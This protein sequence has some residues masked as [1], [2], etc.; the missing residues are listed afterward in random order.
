M[1]EWQNRCFR[2]SFWGWWALN[3]FTRIC[4]SCSLWGI[5]Q[6]KRKSGNSTCGLTLLQMKKPRSV[7]L[8]YPIR[9]SPPENLIDHNVLVLALVIFFY[10]D[11]FLTSSLLQSQ[12]S[13]LLILDQF[14]HLL[15]LKAWSL[16]AF[17]FVDPTK[18]FISNLLF[19]GIFNLIIKSKP[20]VL[21]W[22]KM[23]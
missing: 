22:Y 6:K 9:S 12:R 3:S 14:T 23:L 20:S 15:I 7:K 16:N 8:T 19:A 17:V 2:S 18:Q 21:G 11:H 5:Q 4:M 13:T 10:L 1:Q